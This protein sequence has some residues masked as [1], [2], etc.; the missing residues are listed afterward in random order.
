MNIPLLKPAF[1]FGLL[2][3]VPFYAHAGGNHGHAHGGHGHGHDDAAQAEEARHGPHGG[4]LLKSNDQAF[5]LEVT[6][7]E[8]GVPTEMRLY[9]YSQQ[10]D[11]LVALPSDQLDVTVTLTRIDEQVTQLRF[12][13]E[14]DY[15][16]ADQTIAEPHSFDVMVEVN[17]QGKYFQW[18]YENYEGRI[19]IS[20]RQIDAAGIQVEPVSDRT[21]TFKKSIYG[22]IASS[23]NNLHSLIVPYDSSL[24]SIQVQ[25]GDRVKKGQVLATLK[26]LK[27]LRTY[28]LKSPAKGEITQKIFNSG[29]VLQGQSLVELVDLSKVWVNLSVFPKVL[30]HLKIGQIV[31]ITDVHNDHETTSKIRYVA[32][33]M[34]EGH[35]ARVRAEI[36]NPDGFWRPGMHIKAAI[37]TDR[38]IAPM[39]VKNSAIQTMWGKKVV[40]AKFD[41]QFE[42]RM[43]ELGESDGEYTQVYQGIQPNQAYVT[44]NSFLLKADVLKAGA[45]HDH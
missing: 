44:E 10:A 17:F 9:G 20:P 36:D 16:V 11:N 38:Y 25:I 15:L 31:T 26:N 6:F 1:L 32:P 12:R 13:P 5:Q 2:I 4:H 18:R 42:V 28:T 7:Y 45:I 39:A 8:T 22:T 29:V 40:F 14:M 19:A 27:T 30:Q 23:E 41:D 33:T 21:L 35:I 43:L 37:E 3:C 24:E 34:I